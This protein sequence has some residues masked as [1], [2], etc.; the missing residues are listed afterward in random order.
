MLLQRYEARGAWEDSKLDYSVLTPGTLNSLIT[1]INE[2]MIAS[3][4]VR[5][6][7]RMRRLLNLRRDSARDVCQAQL[8]CKGFYFDDREA[9]T[10]GSDGFIGFAGWADEQN[11][12]PI[13]T[14]FIRWV[15]NISPKT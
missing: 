4:L 1:C 5:K 15:G 11:V 3:G 2:D 7:F 12:Q 6:T 9:V 14:G 10:F 8:R 13:L